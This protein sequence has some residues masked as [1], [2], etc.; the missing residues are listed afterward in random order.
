MIITP[1]RGDGMKI[2]YEGEIQDET[3][4]SKYDAI[5][6]ASRHPELWKVRR[7][8]EEAKELAMKDTNLDGKCGSCKHSTPMGTSCYIT[9]EK[10]YVCRPRSQ[11]KCN[12]YERKVDS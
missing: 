1:K 2:I 11:K 6:Y 4:C 8:K 7:S 9:C 5:A 3:L 12:S 10:G